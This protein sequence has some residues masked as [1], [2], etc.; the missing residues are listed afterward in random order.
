MEGKHMQA[1][2]EVGRLVST[3]DL[4]LAR[5]LQTIVKLEEITHGATPERLIQARGTLSFMLA[6]EYYELEATA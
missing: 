1:L 2:I 3:T 5:K 6:G 4:K